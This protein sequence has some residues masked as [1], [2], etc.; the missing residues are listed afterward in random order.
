MAYLDPTRSRAR[1]S[2]R[3]LAAAALVASHGDGAGDYEPGAAEELQALG[4]AGVAVAGRLDPLV[5]QLL[6][7][8]T[9]A[10]LEILVEVSGFGEAAHLAW[11]TPERAALGV[12]L[13]EDT[14]EYTL[15]EPLLLPWGLAVALG[16]GHRPVPKDVEPVEVTRGTLEAATTALLDATPEAAL[17]ALL[18]A[19]LE[20]GAARR[21][22]FLLASR[23][24]TWR[25]SNR[26]RD[27]SG[28]PRA[29]SATVVDGDVAGYW[30]VETVQDPPLEDPET[31]VRLVPTRP[32]VVWAIL[33]ALLPD[34]DPPAAPAGLA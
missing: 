6:E 18:A 19:G 7:V 25:A 24:S 4:A 10:P 14:H 26:W 30:L 11:V 21:L 23:R 17:A 34:V 22:A 28:Q 3:E 31:P 33:C 32:S 5:G 20:T 9:A 16:I 12:D 1:L 2:S 29:T 8:V 15:V 27:P 13:G